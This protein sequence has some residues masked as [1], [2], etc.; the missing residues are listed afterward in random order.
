MDTEENP[1]SG[2][3][4]RR[5]RNGD[6]DAARD[7]F[8]R[9]VRRLTR[10]AEQQLG[11]PLASRLDGEDVV[12]SVFRTFFR[13]CAR[14][15][16]KIESSAQTWRLLV[17]ITLRKSW[18]KARHHTAA[19]RDLGAET[20]SDRSAWFE[21]T[22]SRTPSPHEATTLADELE[23]VLRGL[24]PAY[25]QM[26]EMRLQGY[27]AAEIADQMGVSR[28]TVYRVLRLLQERL[29]QRDRS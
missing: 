28:Q 20:V 15:E 24:P 25:V 3:L 29:Q 7:L 21:E 18:A 8:E 17:R 1:S 27:T 6:E 16:F 5:W 14:G 19:I 13:R 10:L 4:I 23:F 26:V 22:V 12:Q 2:E 9:Y 11:A